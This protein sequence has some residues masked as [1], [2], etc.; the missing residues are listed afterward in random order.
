MKIFV[1]LPQALPVAKGMPDFKKMLQ[2]VNSKNSFESLMVKI[3]SNKPGMPLDASNL[4]DASR[5]V[6]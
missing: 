4:Y 3:T 1:Y 6:S 2:L 5:N